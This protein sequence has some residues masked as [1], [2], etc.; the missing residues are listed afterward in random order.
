MAVIPKVLV[1]VAN[2]AATGGLGDAGL[3]AAT[4]VPKVFNGQM[5]VEKG[6]RLV[7]RSGARGSAQGAAWIGAQAAAVGVVAAVGAPA[8]A[9]VAVGA[10]AAWVVGSLFDAIFG[11]KDEDDE[12]DE[13]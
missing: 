8:A 13:D 4:V 5:S 3:T 11:D 12:D 7:V 2:G 9:V 6:A 1:K 10:G